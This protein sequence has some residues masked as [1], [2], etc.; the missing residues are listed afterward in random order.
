MNN[1]IGKFLICYTGPRICKA[2]KKQ[3]EEEIS[4]QVNRAN[5]KIRKDIM[6]KIGAG[7]FNLGIPVLEIEYVKLVI[8]IDGKIEKH[9]CKLTARKYR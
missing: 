3:E 9:P 2:R 7:Q 1:D 5:S 4:M 6:E 8:T